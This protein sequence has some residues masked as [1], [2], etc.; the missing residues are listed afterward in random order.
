MIAP[1]LMRT[2]FRRQSVGFKVKKTLLF[3]KDKSDE[4]RTKNTIEEIFNEIMFTNF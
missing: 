4:K 1:T 2:R 3:V